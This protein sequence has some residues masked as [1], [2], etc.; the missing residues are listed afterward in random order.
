MTQGKGSL[1][2]KV[3]RMVKEVLR[4]R[5][6][7]KGPASNRPRGYLARKA[8]VLSFWLL[9]GFMFLVVTS[10]LL[11]K[12]DSIKT[13]AEQEAGPEENRAASAEGVQFAQNFARNYLT[14]ANTDEGRKSREKVLGKYLAEGL[15]KYGGLEM[16]NL[17]WDSAVK[18][19]ELRRVEEDGGNRAYITLYVT[20]DLTKAGQKEDAS[21]DGPEGE[22]AAKAKT[23]KKY[24]VVPVEYTGKTFG[25]FELPKFTRLDEQTDLR[26]SGE[27]GLEAETE[28]AGN[29]R[30]FLETF[31]KSYAEDST[32]ELAY[33]TK[34]GKAVQGLDQTMRFV[35]IT[36]SD[37]Y[38]GKGPESF[39]ARVEI[40]LE[41]PETKMRFRTMHRLTL[42]KEEGRYIVT[43]MDEFEGR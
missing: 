3:R 23:M 21:P 30:R 39:V 31:F 15:D 26:A 7:K 2:K 9:F 28:E 33:M 32:D 11:G 16:D 10:T 19:T 25:V 22:E 13:D 34:G 43:G 8:G 42:E 24:L 5:E 38:K 17:G 27:K 37:I 35:E 18:R 36:K 20:A 6:G 29:I 14:W 4:P 1:M 40:Q 12:S 41:E